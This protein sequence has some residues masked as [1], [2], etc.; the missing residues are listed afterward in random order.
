MLNLL[1]GIFRQ[2][3]YIRIFISESALKGVQRVERPVLLYHLQKSCFV[4]SSVCPFYLSNPSFCNKN[5][6]KIGIMEDKSSSPKIVEIV[7]KK[8]TS[9]E[10]NAANSDEKNQSQH[11]RKR[12]T[13]AENLKDNILKW[14]ASNSAGQKRGKSNTHKSPE[15]IDLE[16]P[17]SSKTDDSDD[18]GIIEV[19]PKPKPPK[20]FS[21]SKGG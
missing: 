8:E 3:V 14:E 9:L 7:E 15:I 21:D 20:V 5:I 19:V 17:E 18:I 10:D 12:K 4:R 6:K 11:K 2:R 1:L 16:S 13:V